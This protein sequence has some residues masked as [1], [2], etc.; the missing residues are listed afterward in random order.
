ME[1]EIK[2]VSI[3]K[4]NILRNI[5]YVMFLTK[6][7]FPILN[8]KNNIINDILEFYNDTY[9]T[10]NVDLLMNLKYMFEGIIINSL[11]STG[12]EVIIDNAPEITTHFGEPEPLTPEMVYDTVE[13]FTGEGTVNL[14]LQIA[15]NKYAV[16]F[17]DIEKGYGDIVI[18]YLSLN[19][20]ENNILEVSKLERLDILS[21]PAIVLLE[22]NYLM[23]KTIEAFSKPIETTIEITNQT[24]IEITN[25]TTPDT[26][27][28]TSGDDVPDT[29]TLEEGN[30]NNMENDK[31]N[32]ISFFEPVA[33]SGDFNKP[34]YMVDIES[35]FDFENGN[36]LSIWD[37]LL[38]YISEL[39]KFRNIFSI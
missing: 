32:T 10:E 21:K 25:E 17:Q 39:F 35:N 12:F 9:N 3:Y 5:E 22:M 7:G 19:K 23:M 30:N 28:N 29:P 36:K 20:M 4:Q 37:Q 2:Q 24:T 1:D 27:I 15:P 38:R 13:Y 33:F 31:D 11:E 18:Q 16:R 34:I 8:Y 14:V 26:N 6:Q